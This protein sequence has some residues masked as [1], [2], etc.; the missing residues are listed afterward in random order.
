M[1]PQNNVILVPV[2]FSETSQK[3]V[4]MATELA[5]KLGLEIVLLHVYEPPVLVYPDVSPGL[6]VSMYQELLAAGKRSLEALA[7]RTGVTRTLFREGSAGHEIVNAAGELHPRMIVIG[8]HGRRG[9]RRILMGS[10]AE[11]VLRHSDVPV[12]SVRAEAGG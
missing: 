2:D 7:A 11:Y 9:I 8:T 3:A 12:L 10:V 6:M 1:E 4:D 5:G